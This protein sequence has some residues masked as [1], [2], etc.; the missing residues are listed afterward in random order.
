MEIEYI[1]QLQLSYMRIELKNELGRT[2][3]EMLSHNKIPGILSVGWQRE[4]KRVLLRYD[5]TGKL[6]LDAMLEEK[7]ADALLLERLFG[8]ICNATKQLEKFLLSPEGILLSPEAVFCDYKT[9]EL[10]FCYFPE[11]DIPFSERLEHL[12]EYLL[13]KTDHKNNEAVELAYGLYEELLKPAYSL[14]DIQRFL[15]ERRM[16]RSDKPDMEETDAIMDKEEAESVTEPQE[17]IV[18]WSM[19]GWLNDKKRSVKDWMPAWIKGTQWTKIKRQRPR[20]QE[21]LFE[22]DEKEEEQ[23]AFATELLGERQESAKR[24]LKYEGTDAL[25][26]VYITRYPFLIGSAGDC[27]GILKGFGISRHHARI[28]LKEDTYFIEDLNSTNGTMVEG[29]LLTYK[30]K[31]SIKKGS[32]I[33]FA[34]QPYRFL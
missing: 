11:E 9:G 17:R 21:L 16:H 15:Q 34:N 29:G 2:E 27:D 3:E 5:I 4:D 26:D 13:T 32:V 10:F 28:L 31:V 19:R 12:M 20:K 25:P 14:T 23:E 33:C 22:M 8:G 18:R 1:R 7:K 6:A 24:M 30:T